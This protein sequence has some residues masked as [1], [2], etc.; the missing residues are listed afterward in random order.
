MDMNE[1]TPVLKLTRYVDMHGT[2]IR[3][4]D[5]IKFLWWIPGSDGLQHERYITGRI[6]ERNGKLVFRYRDNF[7]K[8]GKGFH[9]RRLD[10]LCFDS[11]MEWELMVGEDAKYCIER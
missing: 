5:W 3:V 10:S 6:F 2:R 4:G 9:E 7:K 11:T 1:T 8:P